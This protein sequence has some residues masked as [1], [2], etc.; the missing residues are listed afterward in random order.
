MR[1]ATRRWDLLLSRNSYICVAL[2]GLS[3]LFLA[4]AV[5]ESNRELGRTLA[6]GTHPALEMRSDIWAMCFATGGSL[7]AGGIIGYLSYPELTKAQSRRFFNMAVLIGPASFAGR[8]MIACVFAAELYNFENP[9]PNGQPISMVLYRSCSVWSDRFVFLTAGCLSVVAVH[10]L[11][12]RQLDR[13]IRRSLARDIPHNA[14]TCPDC[15]YCLIGIPDRTCPEC[16]SKAA[17]HGESAGADG[18]ERRETITHNAR[19]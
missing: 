1:S 15:G 5:S 10:V 14:P 12:Q 8:G 18:P 17:P 11:I 3:F 2:L 13:R 6:A 19:P 4:D 7:L 9:P 16:G